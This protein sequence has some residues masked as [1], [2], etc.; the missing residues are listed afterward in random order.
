M[1]FSEWI[2]FV[3]VVG[4]YGCVCM[5]KNVPFCLFVSAVVHMCVSVC[6][7]VCMCMCVCVC[8]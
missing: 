4:W 8:V 5:C 7:C 2:V 3:Y 1:F 6:I